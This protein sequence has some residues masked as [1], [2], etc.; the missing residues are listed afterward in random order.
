MCESL[1]SGYYALITDIVCGAN[2]IIVDYQCQACASDELAKNNICEKCETP[3]CNPPLPPDDGCKPDQVIFGNECADACPEGYDRVPTVPND[4]CVKQQPPE[5]PAPKPFRGSRSRSAPREEP[6]KDPYPVFLLVVIPYALFGLLMPIFAI[7]Q[8]KQDFKNLEEGKY[9]LKEEQQYV[10]DK[11]RYARGYECR[12]EV[13][14]IEADIQKYSKMSSFGCCNSMITFFRTIHPLFSLFAHYDYKMSR[15]NRLLLV[16]GQMGLITILV[17]LAFTEPINEWNP[18]DSDNRAWY[19]AAVLCILTI[20]LPRCMFRFLER[21]LYVF[22][23]KDRLQ[24]LS[25]Y[26]YDKEGDKTMTK[27]PE[28]TP[29]EP[30]AGEG[31]VKTPSNANF[32][33]NLHKLKT[34]DADYIKNQKTTQN[35]AFD[36]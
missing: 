16:L 11:L 3:D 7:M 36:P 18:V 15:M 27:K 1:K 23:G 8:D 34:L 25:A 19:F 13:Y 24:S 14:L 30:T 12:E 4:L 29:A 32:M 22:K 33:D 2:E 28:S 9:R 17:V 5:P 6:P 21:E 31:H 20:P 10:Y 26:E 35:I